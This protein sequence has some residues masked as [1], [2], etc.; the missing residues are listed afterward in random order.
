MTQIGHLWPISI[1]PALIP[2]VSRGSRRSSETSGGR[3]QRLRL[4]CSPGD[5]GAV[6]GFLSNL[7]TPNWDGLL[8]G[9]GQ[10]WASVIFCGR[11]WQMLALVWL[12]H[13]AVKP[14]TRQ[15]CERKSLRPRTKEAGREQKW[16]NYSTTWDADPGDPSKNTHN[17]GCRVLD[18]SS[19][20][21]EHQE[22]YNFLYNI[23]Y[24]VIIITNYIC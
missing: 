10:T 24:I 4:S 11:C 12:Q 21:E 19:K 16:C 2:R 22:P 3:L 15:V 5:D 1:A 14:Q 6:P 9:H 20:N 7:G 8:D 23:Y 17:S 18:S 13:A